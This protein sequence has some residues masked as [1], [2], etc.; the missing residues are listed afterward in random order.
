[1]VMLS[2]ATC[3]GQ[4]RGGGVP[5][6]PMYAEACIIVKMRVLMVFFREWRAV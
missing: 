3:T 4:G 1:M 6:T 5:P 2:P